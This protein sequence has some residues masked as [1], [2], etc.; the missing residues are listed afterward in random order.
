[1][2]SS[3]GQII[4]VV[5]DDEWVCRSVRNLFLSHG[6]AVEVFGSAEAFLQ[7]GRL[8][9]T[10][11]LILDLRMP[12]MSGLDLLHALSAV[13]S[14]IPT[15]VLTAHSDTDACVSCLQAGALAVLQKPFDTGVLVQSVKTVMSGARGRS[16]NPPSRPDF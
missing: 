16:G 7:S 2:G 11:C 15:I 5:D 4:A 14:E 3:A 12:G 6:F 1:M 10:A 8:E 9:D 13:G